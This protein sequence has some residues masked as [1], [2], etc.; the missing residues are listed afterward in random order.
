[1]KTI[2]SQLR[3]TGNEYINEIT[4][5]MNEYLVYGYKNAVDHFGKGVGAYLLPCDD[6]YISFRVP[7]ATR[8]HIEVKDGIIKKFEF[9]ERAK[10]CFIEDIE[11]ATQEYIGCKLILGEEGKHD[12]Q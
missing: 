2:T 9:Y 10:D 12:G 6:T 3:F 4:D 11:A 7:G 8:G 1:M 5:K